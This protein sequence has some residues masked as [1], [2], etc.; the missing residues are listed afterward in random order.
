VQVLGWLAVHGA[1][2]FASWQAVR[3]LRAV[4]DYRVRIKEIELLKE[5][6]G[7]VSGRQPSQQACARHARR[8]RPRR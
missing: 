6:S 7:L 8:R 1:D 4:L 2:W 3:A 5:Q